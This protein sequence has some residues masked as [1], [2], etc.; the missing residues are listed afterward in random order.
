MIDCLRSNRSP[1]INLAFE[2]PS[3]SACQYSPTTASLYVYHHKVAGWLREL[4]NAVWWQC[5][6]TSRS[7]NCLRVPIPWSKR[8]R[9]VGDGAIDFVSPL[10]LRSRYDVG[11]ARQ[12]DISRRSS[13]QIIVNRRAPA[14]LPIISLKFPRWLWQRAQLHHARS[15]PISCF[16][17]DRRKAAWIS[18]GR[19]LNLN[20]QV[21]SSSRNSKVPMIWRCFT[22]PS[23]APLPQ[24]VLMLPGR[25]MLVAKPKSPWQV[26]RRSTYFID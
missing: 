14:L 3:T 15:L 25:F 17:H 13:C 1:G 5:W 6:R 9:K 10:I 18:I 12:E 22:I 26:I 20:R 19:I 16:R 21:L 24:P 7:F 2:K 4:M 11:S 23:S 8:S